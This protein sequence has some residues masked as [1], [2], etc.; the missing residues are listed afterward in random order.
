MITDVNLYFKNAIFCV[1]DSAWADCFVNKSIMVF[2]CYC[3]AS[4]VLLFH[5][6]DNNMDYLE[7]NVFTVSFHLLFNLLS[8]QD[9]SVHLS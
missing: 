3:L 4:S 2:G 5:R 1:L 9:V 6:K 7:N 8:R